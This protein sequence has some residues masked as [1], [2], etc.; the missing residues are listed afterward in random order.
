MCNSAHYANKTFHCAEDMRA[1]QAFESSRAAC[2][3]NYAMQADRT[4]PNGHM[5]MQM[6]PLRKMGY[7]VTLY[8]YLHVRH[9][10]PLHTRGSTFTVSGYP[11]NA[12][13]HSRVRFGQP[14]RTCRYA[15]PLSVQSARLNSMLDIVPS[16]NYLLTLSFAEN[17]TCRGRS[18]S[19]S[20]S[21]LSTL[22][23][24]GRSHDSL[25]Y[26]PLSVVSS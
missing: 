19:S 12:R 1:V 15:L 10:C 14:C 4:H 26:N 24:A 21:F 16:A 18:L 22:S 2:V 3:D 7:M 8:G 9:A 13:A 11:L 5:R 23:L 6:F 17:V 25:A 20:V